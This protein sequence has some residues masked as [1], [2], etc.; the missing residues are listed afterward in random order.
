MQPDQNFVPQPAT[1]PVAPV[2]PVTPATSVTPSFAPKKKSNGMLFGLI[3]AIILALGGI[4]FGVWMMMN[5]K[6]D[7]P[8]NNTSD[9]DTAKYIYVGEWGLKIGIP[10]GLKFV[11]Y[12]YRQSGWTGAMEKTTVA[13]Y[14]TVA[15]YMLDFANPYNNEFTNPGTVIRLHKDTFIGPEYEGYEENEILCG[16]A[17]A[18]LV[19]ESGDYNYCYER[20]E[21]L[22]SITEETQEIETQSINLIKQMLTNPENYSEI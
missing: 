15:D 12:L 2:A 16:S 21:T 10:E 3:F 4:G 7:T 22:Y 5:P 11:S 6:C 13:V 18:E 8:E 9:V 1:Q 19:F 17:D 14:G 20:S